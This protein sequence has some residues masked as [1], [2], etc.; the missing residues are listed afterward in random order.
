MPTCH[1]DIRSP[2]KSFRW[3]HATSAWAEISNYTKYR[4]DC[5]WIWMFRAFSRSTDFSFRL[6][7]CAAVAALVSIS[8]KTTTSIQWCWFFSQFLCKAFTFSFF[9]YFLLLL[10]STHSMYLILWATTK[11]TW[12][13][14]EKNSVM[15]T[16]E[17]V[18]EREEEEKVMKK[19]NCWMGKRVEYIRK[20]V[21][22]H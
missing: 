17:W 19:K 10:Y 1:C 9:L 18:S 15:C 14:M 6:L 2:E 7:C 11:D 13:G 20:G 4:F 5:K 16:R 22:I 12:S 3:S 21:C 8:N